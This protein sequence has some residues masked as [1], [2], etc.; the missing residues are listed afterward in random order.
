MHCKLNTMCSAWCHLPI[1]DWYSC[2]PA[3]CYGS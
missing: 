2:I 1:S 3:K